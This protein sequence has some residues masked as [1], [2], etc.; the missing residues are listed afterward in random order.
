MDLV[1]KF[2]IKNSDWPFFNFIYRRKIGSKKHPNFKLLK[3]LSTHFQTE[4]SRSFEA[5]IQGLKLGMQLFNS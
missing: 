4:Y 1:K 2:K 3:T 5:D